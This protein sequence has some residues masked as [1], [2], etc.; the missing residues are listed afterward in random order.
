MNE[1]KKESEQRN[2]RVYL[3]GFMGSGKSTIGPILANTIGYEFVDID[4]AIEAQTGKIV[5]E[6]FQNQG[7]EYFRTLE[8]ALL[9]DLRSRDHIVI[10]LGGGTI[11]DPVSFP[12]IRES[13]ILVYLRTAPEHLFKRLHHKSDRPIL[14][15]ASGE[16]L[17]EDALRVRI[18]EVYARRRQFY[19]QADIIISTDEHKVGITVDQIVRRLSNLLD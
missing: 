10:S 4:R 11:A 6:I 16:R 5:R 9:G 2:R 14:V 1:S 3:T 8:R 15:D 17:S 12:L 18:E 13:G 19:E 7:E